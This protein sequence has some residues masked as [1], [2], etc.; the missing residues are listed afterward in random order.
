MQLLGQLDHGVYVD[1]CDGLSVNLIN[2]YYGVHGREMKKKPG[3]SGA[4]HAPDDEDNED[5]GWATDN[6]SEENLPQSESAAYV[7]TE[8]NIRHEP[9]SVPDH[10]PPF[11]TIEF[12]AFTTSLQSLEAT[13]WIPDGYG[14][15]PDEWESVYYP[16]AENIP[17]GRRS[18]K[19][20]EISLSTSLWYPRAQLWCRSLYL[21]NQISFQRL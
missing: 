14:I 5:D 17:L 4:G 18:Q 6:E 8:P 21:M 19:V 9:V 13:N 7:E 16:T 12:Q 11:S 15:H 3:Q 1:D 2:K 10:I 20:M